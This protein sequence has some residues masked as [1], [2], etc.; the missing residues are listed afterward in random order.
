MKR[1]TGTKATRGQE[2]RP[3]PVTNTLSSSFKLGNI[4]RLR[5]RLSRSHGESESSCVSITPEL[6]QSLN[7]AI[8][9]RQGRRKLGGTVDT[10]RGPESV[11]GLSR[12]HQQT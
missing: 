6:P 7:T 11:G 9:N 2:G 4:C 10:F 5:P 1:R 12:S 3:A 8:K